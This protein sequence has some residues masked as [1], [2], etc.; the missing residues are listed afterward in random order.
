MKRFY[1]IPSNYHEIEHLIVTDIQQIKRIVLYSDNTILFYDTC[2]FQKHANLNDNE[3]DILI[4]YFLANNA[5]IFI[6]RCILM[7]LIG[8]IQLLN[9]KYIHYFKRLYEKNLKVVIFEEEYTYDLLS[10]F[11]SANEIINENLSFAVKTIKTPTSTIEHTLNTNKTLYQELVMAKNL[12]KSAIYKRFFSAVRKNKEHQDN[13]GEEMIG[14]CIY[15]MSCISSV[16]E[17]KVWVLTEDKIAKTKF[18]TVNKC[19]KKLGIGSRCKVFSTPKLVQYMYR[20][21]V[22][23]TKEEM[24]KL[25]AQGTNGLISVMGTTTLDLDV[26]P[27][28]SMEVEELV[29]K[30]IEPNAINIVF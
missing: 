21:S 14:L 26:N 13:L 19:V 18:H 5:V 4:R 20:D 17:G 6:T 29:E 27:K 10:D 2:S 30:I 3:M 12:T 25:I 16:S 24:V 23:L 28:I 15:L 1:E 7:E 9:E 22:P 8:D 11:E